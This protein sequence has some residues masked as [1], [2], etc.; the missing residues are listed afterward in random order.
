MMSPSLSLRL[1]NMLVFYELLRVIFLPSLLI[2]KPWLEY[3]I[4]ILFVDIEVILLKA[5]S[6][7]HVDSDAKSLQKVGDPALVS[8]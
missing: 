4:L 3:S 2:A 5:F 1:L 6:E 8:V 7:L